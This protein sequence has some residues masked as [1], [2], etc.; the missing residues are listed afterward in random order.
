ME[1][2][3]F[4]ERLMIMMRIKILIN[5]NTRRRIARQDSLALFCDRSTVLHM[6]TDS[7]IYISTVR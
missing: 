4:P 1:T 7:F 6:N 3:L 5:D 2:V